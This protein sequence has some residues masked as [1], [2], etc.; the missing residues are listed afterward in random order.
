[1]EGVQEIQ[2]GAF[3]MTEQPLLNGFMR[4]AKP[5]EVK[6]YRSYIAR[7]R[8][9]ARQDWELLTLSRSPQLQRRLAPGAKPRSPAPPTQF[10]T[11]E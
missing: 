3:Q 9:F 5:Q 11:E 10:P 8:Y 4:F 2:E 1:M 7:S 6:N